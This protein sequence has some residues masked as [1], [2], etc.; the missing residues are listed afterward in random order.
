M[1]H[2]KF[3]LLIIISYFFSVE[4][5]NA[6]L[7]AKHFV[8]NNKFVDGIPDQQRTHKLHLKEVNEKAIEVDD[9]IY[10]SK[11]LLY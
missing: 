8:A 1:D 3:N 11:S 5:L 10:F 4:E 7:Y 9:G 2:P 6:L